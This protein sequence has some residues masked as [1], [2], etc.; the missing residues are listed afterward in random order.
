M[1]AGAGA[2]QK[3]TGSATLVAA[4][5][6][7]YLQKAGLRYRHFLWIRIWLLISSH[8]LYCITFSLTIDYI[9]DPD[10]RFF[11]IDHYPEKNLADPTRSVSD[12]KLKSGWREPCDNY[13]LWLYV[14]FLICLN[15]F[16]NIWMKRENLKIIQHYFLQ[17]VK[18]SA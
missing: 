10:R 12:R 1:G 16:L 9:Q 2:G 7:R 5:T 17:Y 3:R 8:F 15:I 14:L 4:P 18:F 13:L 6:N 11:F